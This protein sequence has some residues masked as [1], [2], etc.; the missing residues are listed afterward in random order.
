MREDWSGKKSK[1]PKEPKQDLVVEIHESELRSLRRNANLGPIALV[2]VVLLA[3]LFG[4]GYYLDNQRETRNQAKVAAQQKALAATDAQLNVVVQNHSLRD[5]E[6]ALKTGAVDKKVDAVAGTANQAFALARETKAE[7][8]P[9]TEQLIEVNGKLVSLAEADTALAVVDAI[10]NGRMNLLASQVDSFR[11]ETKGAID[12][13]LRQ[14][15]GISSQLSAGS[16]QLSRIQKRQ[17][18]FNIGDLILHGITYYSR[19]G[20]NPSPNGKD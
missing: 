5:A 10:T 6:H 8:Q 17:L 3:G 16:E 7:I 18:L 4:V 20:P 9:M 13:V 12:T 14:Q 15:A 19:Y 2:L 1:E 11:V